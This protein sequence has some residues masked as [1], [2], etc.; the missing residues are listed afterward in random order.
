[1]Q[2]WLI[3]WEDQ[4]IAVK[5]VATEHS[6]Q[7]SRLTSLQMHRTL[8]PGLGRAIGVSVSSEML[9]AMRWIGKAIGMFKAENLPKS[10]ML[11]SMPETLLEF[12]ESERLSLNSDEVQPT[13]C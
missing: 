9:F 2:Q 6:E 8:Q 7:S 3:G 11:A 12:L 5:L 1:M 4:R 10:S 13:A